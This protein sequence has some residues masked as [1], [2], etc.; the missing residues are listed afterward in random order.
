MPWNT[1]DAMSLKEEFIA[2]ALQ[3]DSNRRE[4]CRRFGISPQT[5]YK[6]LKR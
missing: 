4:L 5:A 6:W 1:R 2:L 3:P